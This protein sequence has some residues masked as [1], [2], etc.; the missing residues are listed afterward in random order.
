MLIKERTIVCEKKK[1]KVFLI[2]TKYRMHIINRIDAYYLTLDS[3]LKLNS[4]LLFSS[5]RAITRKL[6]SKVEIIS[7][8]GKHTRCALYIIHGQCEYIAS[9]ILISFFAYP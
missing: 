1:S 6:N 7:E 8:V 2:E 3:F 9:S 5:K 4:V